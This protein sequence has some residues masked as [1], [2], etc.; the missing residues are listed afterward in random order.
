M[1][2]CD[3]Q[4]LYYFYYESPPKLSRHATDT[5]RP[6]IGLFS[7]Y[8]R[9]GARIA[10]RKEKRESR[11]KTFLRRKSRLSIFRKVAEYN[12]SLRLISKNDDGQNVVTWWLRLFIW[13][14]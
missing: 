5:A 12:P 8:I 6:A 1:M 13:Y 14:H 10:Q 11:R 3:E 7:D 9:E 2:R 4:A